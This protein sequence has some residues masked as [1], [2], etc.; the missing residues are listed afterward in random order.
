[1]EKFLFYFYFYFMKKESSL[2]SLHHK[3]TNM[4]SPFPL[5]HQDVNGSGVHST[6]KL[7]QFSYI[8]SNLLSISDMKM[9]AMYVQTDPPYHNSLLLT[10][11]FEHVWGWL[12]HDET[13]KDN[14]SIA[15]QQPAEG[16][17]E[18]RRREIYD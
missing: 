8:Y 11:I 13:H 1:M 14:S 17:E 16:C 3:Q 4:M 5:S 6:N 10:T 2:M 12:L 18:V 15:A 9:Y 7:T